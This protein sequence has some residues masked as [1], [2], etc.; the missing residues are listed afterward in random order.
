MTV[1][2]DH[3]APLERERPDT[4]AL[5]WSEKALALAGFLIFMGA[6]REILLT[7]NANRTGGSAL[8]QLV[9]GAVYLSAIVV[10]VARGIPV[11]AFRVL[12]HSWPLLLLTIL[13][14]LSTLWSQ[15]PGATLRRAVTLI[16][17]STFA[18]FIIVRFNPRT[19]FNIILV[20]FAIFIVTGALAAAVPGLG[21]T[22][23][24]QYAGAWRGLTGQKNVFGRTLALA[25]M[26]LP[27]AAATGLITR[28]RLAVLFSLFAFALLIL[29]RSVTSLIAAVTSVPLGVLLYVGLGGRFRGVRLRPELGIT[30]LLIAA[31]TAFIAL[32]YG[33]T[34]VLE[35]LGRDPTLT[36]RTDIW[37]WAIAVNEGREWLGSGFRAFWIDANT[38]YYSEFFWLDDLEGGRS[39]TWRGPDHAHSAY[40]DQYLELGYLGVALLVTTILAAVLHL[41][42][43]LTYG[44]YDDHKIGLIFAT[45]ISFLLVY[46]TSE[47]SFLQHSE[48]LWF[49]FIL[50]YLTSV[51]LSIV[52]LQRPNVFF[53]PG[54]TRVGGGFPSG[55]GG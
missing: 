24:G 42:R 14:L 30:M 55:S 53:P 8:F 48:E 47:R 40:V 12:V 50:F 33:S 4:D 18:I 16:L 41:R 22:P 38:L 44:T 5:A 39:D 52:T 26:L 51:K 34:I 45:I 7:G 19:T 3:V 13:P 36:G 17:S 35:A 49:F 11:W 27:L 23:G 31:V 10:L 2:E 1:L 29:S 21:I 46:S 9:S 37:R 54:A 20:A 25:V 15:D 6:F 28:R 43:M 32:R